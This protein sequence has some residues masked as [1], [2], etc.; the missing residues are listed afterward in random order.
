MS[1]PRAATLSALAPLLAVLAGAPPAAAAPGVE[2]HRVASLAAPVQA[3]SAPGKR[4]RKLTFVVERAGRVMVVDS[5]GL[6]RRP[7]LDIRDRVR[8]GGEEGLL[9]IAFAPDYRESRRLYAY[10]TDRDSNI[11]VSGFRARRGSKPVVRAGS[12]RRVI[13]IPHPGAGNHN[14]G[15]LA[16]G[17]DRKLWL[18]PGDGGGACDPRR[19]AQNPHSLLGKLLRIAPRP[20][21]GYRIPPGNP[22]RGRSGRGEIWALGLRNPFR[23]SFAPGGALAIA[24]VGQNAREEINYLGRGAA[25][26]ANFGWNAFEGSRPSGCPTAAPVPARQILPIHEYGH[27]GPGHSGCSVT[28]GIV[29]RGKR[30]P[31]LRGRYVYADYC[32]GRLR[33]LIP[34]TAGARDERAVGTSVPAPTSFH[35]V[36]RGPV[37]VTSLRGGLYRLRSRP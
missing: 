16:F 33:S 5:G 11:R 29:V 28:G 18:A 27:S 30:I 6:R 12:E 2:A 21:G 4:N 15:Q 10:Y 9:S 14:G 26:G 13:V 31:A 1:W 23:F 8:S 20:T 7:F 32:A 17:P 34:D 19:N 36:R 25:R 24:D 3:V 22:L 37:L 35:Q